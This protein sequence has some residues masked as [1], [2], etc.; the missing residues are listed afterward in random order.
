MFARIAPFAL[1]TALALIPLGCDSNSSVA[2]GTTASPDGA[3]AAVVDAIQTKDKDRFASLL[4]DAARQAMESGAGF[5]LEN[6]EFEGAQIG[7]AEVTGDTATVPVTTG[8]GGEEKSMALRLRRE[9][10]EWKLFGAVADLGNGNSMEIDFETFGGVADQMGQAIAEELGRSMQEAFEKSI[11]EQKEREMARRL[12]IYDALGPMEAGDFDASWTN[13]TDY[14]DRTAREAV[15]DLAQQLG[16]DVDFGHHGAML[17][18]PV[19]DD[20]RGLSK[21]AALDALCGKVRLVP[22]LPSVDVRAGAMATM[23]ETFK[24]AGA[25]DNLSPTT[26]QVVPRRS[27]HRVTFCGPFQVMVEK[28]EEQPPHARGTVTVGYELHGIDAGVIGLFS[29]L[30]Q[31]VRIANVENASGDSLTRDSAQYFVGGTHVE[32]SYHGTVQVELQNL[33]RSIEQVEVLGGTLHL[34]APRRVET[35]TFPSLKVGQTRTVDGVTL[36]VTAVGNSVSVEVKGPDDRLQE[37][38]VFGRALDNEG[39]DVEVQYDSY[40]KW[41]SGKSL[42]QMN[43]AEPPASVALRV[44]LERDVREYPFQLRDI[45]LD[46]F[47]AQPESLAALEFAGGAPLQVKFHGFEKEGD[48]FSNAHLTVTNTSNKPIQA[49][50]VK[51]SYRDPAGKEIGSHVHSVTAPMAMGD[52]GPLVPANGTAESKPTAFF[53]PEGCQAMN[54][55]VESVEFMDGSRWPED[56]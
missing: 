14:R 21:L 40:M 7:R 8:T 32:N 54:P 48:M 35:V 17:D 45:E 23:P 55:T 18:I 9:A 49:A 19:T 11:R 30:S 47:P 44:I 56:Q 16:Y 43:T 27:E 2:H 6:A 4:T 3:A 33:V 24:V 1:V 13:S 25:R 26:M 5:S 51:F 22:V 29:S 15:A 42:Y 36:T 10:N 41:G 20:L 50:Q 38:A 12:A 34:A 53:L 37:L 39:G 52:P 31:T 28:V 46:R